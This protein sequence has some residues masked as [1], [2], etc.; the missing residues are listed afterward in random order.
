MAFSLQNLEYEKI[1]IMFKSHTNLLTNDFELRMKKAISVLHFTYLL[2]SMQ[3]SSNCFKQVSYHLSFYP[4]YATI[5]KKEKN[6]SI[7]FF[8]A[9]LF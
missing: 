8:V 4:Y 1:K 3:R 2:G 6:A 7:L 5:C 9:T